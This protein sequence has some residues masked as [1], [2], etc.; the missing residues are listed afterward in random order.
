MQRLIRCSVLFGVLVGTWA[1]SG[2]P[3][4]NSGKPTL[5][6]ADPTVV[7]V[8]QGDSQGVV[9]YVVDE[10]GQSIASDF[11]AS[12]VGAGITVNLDP[13]FLPTQTIPPTNIGHQA[14]FF[15]KGVA[16]TSTTF[17]VNAS[18]LTK[19]VTVNSLAP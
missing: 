3:T 18:G 14:R 2:D 1:C 10:D 7:F 4:N 5:I 11:A 8:T 17:V 15:V 6:V 13:N 16:V 19:T 9:A 12:N